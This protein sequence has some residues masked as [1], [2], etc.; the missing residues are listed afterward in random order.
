MGSERR[1]AAEYN[2]LPLPLPLL[3]CQRQQELR[4]HFLFSGALGF[5]GGAAL[6]AQSG[7]LP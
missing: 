7:G 5:R 2:P 4:L 3:R 6:S 1:G